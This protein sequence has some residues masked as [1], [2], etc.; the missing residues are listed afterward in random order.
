MVLEV[1]KAKESRVTSCLWLGKLGD[2]CDHIHRER[3]WRGKAL[4]L[5]SRL[6]CYDRDLKNTV[7]EK[8]IK[9]IF[10]PSKCQDSGSSELKTFSFS[11]FVLSFSNVVSIPRS[12]MSG[13][14]LAIMDTYYAHTFPSG[15]GLE[16]DLII[17]VYIHSAHIHGPILITR[18]YQM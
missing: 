10:L 6:G 9:F 7:P 16:T 3:H 4:T 1:R 14:A 18:L 17:S 5:G 13:P 8:K 15:H 2:F 12:K 11:L